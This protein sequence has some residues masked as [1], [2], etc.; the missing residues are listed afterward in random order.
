MSAR[1]DRIPF[2]PVDAPG[3]RL[4]FTPGPLTTTR[5]VR[6]AMAI[7]IG[8]WDTDSIRLAAEIRAELV[9]L[10]GGGERTA[11]LLQGSGSYAV[12]AVI[13]SAVPRGGKLLILSN[14]AY[15]ERMRLTAEALGVPHAVHRDPE[16]RPH[17][18]AV[19]DRL[20]A[21]DRAIT[22]VACVHG[23]T[24]TGLLN[25]AREIGLVVGR[26]GRRVIVDAI[27]T[28]GAYPVGPGAALDLEAGPVDHLVG[29]ANKCL[30]GV[31]G[32]AFVISR[33][34]A[35][36]ACAGNARSLVLDLHGQW[37]HFER[38]GQFR[39]TPPTHVL[40]AFRQALRELEEE[41]GVEARA[42]R[43]E[44]NHRVLVEGME[45]LGFEPYV[46]REHRSRIITTFRYPERAGR[47]FDFRAFYDRLHGLG[48][49]IYPGKLSVVDTIRI[50]TIG[51][52]GR[53][54]V[55]ALLAAVEEVSRGSGP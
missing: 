19:V 41:G 25:P 35:I 4:L 2:P 45:R 40:L 24:T 27:S 12:E 20:L 39:F 53:R 48:F 3:R 28:F 6:A 55:E 38:T 34:P 11:T 14:G 46:A 52:I 36:E 1:D 23:E 13:G 43:Y 7:D 5:S 37:S 31:P 18:P 30:E 21:A 50:A 51:S 16:D 54:E 42:R 26:R 29:S 22:H 17:D 10:A 9:R 44:E 33:R 15:G 47:P 49:I 8:S 32:F